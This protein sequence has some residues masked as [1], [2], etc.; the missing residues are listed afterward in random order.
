[1]APCPT[2]LAVR[3]L[4]ACGAAAIALGLAGAADA[5]TMSASSSTYNAGYGRSAG[6]ENQPI[7]VSM[8][9]ANGNLVI[10][11]GQVLSPTGGSVF[12]TSTTGGAGSSATGVGAGATAIGNNLTVVTTGNYNTV[13]VNSHQT[14][15]GQVTASSSVSGG[16][17]NAQ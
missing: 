8:R 4:T 14:N 9:D 17:G 1:M 12:S 15:T 10:A 11:G 5:Q 2:W 16:V 6:S 13:I 3:R 7:N